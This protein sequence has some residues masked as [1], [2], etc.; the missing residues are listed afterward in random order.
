MRRGK[1]LLTVLL[2]LITPELLTRL[3][4]YNRATLTEPPQ[5]VRILDRNGE[6]LREAVNDEGERSRWVPLAEVSP[7]LIQSTL[8]AED[9]RFFNHPGVDGKSILRAL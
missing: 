3:F 1:H 5:S 6:L 2:L 4:P 8:A 7:L 9:D